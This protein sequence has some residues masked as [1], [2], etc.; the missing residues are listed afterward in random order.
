MSAPS[1]APPAPNLETQLLTE[2]RVAWIWD[3]S[4]RTVRDWRR[5]GTLNCVKKGK[6]VVRYQ[7]CD[8][9]Q[10]I[11]AHYRAT[12]RPPVTGMAGPEDPSWQCMARLVQTAVESWL[13]GAARNV[14][15]V[16]LGEAAYALQTSLEAGDADVTRVEAVLRLIAESLEA[17]IV[18]LREN[19]M[20]P[21][22]ADDGGNDM[23]LDMPGKP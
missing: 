10:D 12:A 16:R 5:Q 6:N 22:G 23:A 11:L 3:V 9:A 14:G 21:D 20:S 1:W 7:P 17:T 19:G 2:E 15:L 18:W 4:P 13:A 8:I